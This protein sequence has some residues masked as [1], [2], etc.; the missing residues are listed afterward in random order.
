VQVFNTTGVLEDVAGTSLSAPL[1]AREAAFAFRELAPYCVD[2]VPFAATVRAWLTLVADRPDF[3]GALEKLAARTVGGGFPSSERIRTPGTDRA[4]FIWQTVLESA[5]TAARVAFPVPLAW[6]QEAK[7]PTLRLVVAWLTP[8]NA[9]LTGTW[10]CRRVGAQVRTSRDADRPALRRGVGAVGAYPTIDSTTDISLGRL[11]ALVDR[12][13]GL[14]QVPA[15]D[16]WSLTVTYEDLGPPPPGIEFAPQQR[17]GVAI[18]LY[19]A[20]EQPVSPQAAVQAAAVPQMNRLS[21]I[22][23]PI[24]VPI[25]IR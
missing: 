17:V 11:A 12:K 14:D 23:A 19:D 22:Q 9:S 18:E 2:G 20:A 7:A 15:D 21:I 25:V 13:T 8:V 1:V 24:K 5:G 10:A 4:V 6:L 16:L 3:G